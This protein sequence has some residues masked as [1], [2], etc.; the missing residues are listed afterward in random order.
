MAQPTRVC[1]SLGYG[2]GLGKVMGHHRAEI[3][4]VGGFLLAGFVECFVSPIEKV[5]LGSWE[6]VGAVAI[7]APNA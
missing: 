7:G 5:A 3:P 4:R 2:V 1:T 6:V